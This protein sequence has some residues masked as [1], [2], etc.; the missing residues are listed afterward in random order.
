MMPPPNLT[1]EDHLKAE[2]FVM[3][4]H[5]VFGMHSIEDS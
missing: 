5:N 1:R 2:V 3:T 4:F